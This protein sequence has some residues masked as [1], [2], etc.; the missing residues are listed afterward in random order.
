MVKAIEAIFD[1]KVFRPAEFIALKPNTKVKITIE[2]I[3]PSKNGEAKSFLQTAREM[4]L[5]GPPDWSAHV[6]EYLYGEE[7]SHAE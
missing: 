1:G 3:Q 7:R 5:D 4:N 2:T 6:K